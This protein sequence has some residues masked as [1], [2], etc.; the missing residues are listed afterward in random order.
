[1]TTRIVHHLPLSDGLTPVQLVRLHKAAARGVDLYF[2]RD[3][4]FSA[5]AKHC[6]MSRRK[7]CRT[8]IELITLFEAAVLREAVSEI[9][10]RILPYGP[11]PAAHPIPRFE[12]GAVVT[13]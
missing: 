6:S 8:R 7:T 2:E 1:M 3:I 10:Q 9:D 12:N 11:I 4:Q 5:V 13:H